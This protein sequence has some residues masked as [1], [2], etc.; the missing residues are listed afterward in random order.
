MGVSTDYSDTLKKGDAIMPT[1]YPVSPTMY[2]QTSSPGLTQQ[3]KTALY[4]TE[5]QSD[6]EYINHR[7]VNFPKATSTNL[8]NWS[9]HN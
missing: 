8:T 4:T 9:E 3:Q 5:Q 7:Y 6:P 1:V 2:G